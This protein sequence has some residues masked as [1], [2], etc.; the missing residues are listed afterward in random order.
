MRQGTASVH[1][2]SDRPLKQGFVLTFLRVNADQFQQGDA[3]RIFFAGCLVRGQDFPGT[4]ALDDTMPQRSWQIDMW[5]D[6]GV[7]RRLSDFH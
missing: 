4:V 5:S 1:S 7:V 3:A 2:K 6:I